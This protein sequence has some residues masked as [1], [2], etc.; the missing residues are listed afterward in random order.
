MDKRRDEAEL[1]RIVEEMD[2]DGDG[3]ISENDLRTCLGHVKHNA[4][5][6]EGSV[7]TRAE[8]PVKRLFPT[9]KLGEDKAIEVARMIR[10]ELTTKR[11]SIRDGKANT[12]LMRSSI[13]AL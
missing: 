1:A 9:E 11:M 5:F 2:L 4:F 8:S 7:D 13:P 10:R 12:G 3:L 6:G